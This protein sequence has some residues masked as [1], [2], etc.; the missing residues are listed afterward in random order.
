MP[1]AFSVSTTDGV[2]ILDWRVEGQALN[3]LDIN[4]IESLK[5]GV[6]GAADNDDVAGIVIT[7]PG[8]HFGGG[9]DISLL[10][11][12]SDGTL[13]INAAY[14]FARRLHAVFRRI[15]TCGKPV[16]AALPGTAAAGAFEL[17]LSCHRRF[18]AENPEARIGLPEIRIGL[19]PGIGGTTRLIRM[20]GLERAGPLLL[21]GRML[22]PEQALK[23]GMVDEV[24]PADSLRARAVRW[25][26]KANGE[27]ATQ[28]WDR[29]GH[30]IPGG[31]AYTRNGANVFAGASA[32]T[33]P[34]NRGNYPAIEALLAV[35]YEGT[36]VSFETALRIEARWIARVLGDPRAKS[37]IRT[38]FLSSRALARGVRRPRTARPAPLSRIG[39]VGAG[40][41]GAGIAYSAA[42][43][44]MHVMLLD[45]DQ[46]AAERGAETVMRI[47]EAGVKRG[48]QSETKAHAI[49]ERVDIGT[50]S[51]ELAECELVIEAV[52]EDPVL[53]GE[54]L[55]RAAS[56]VSKET[57]IATN[58]STLPIT[59]LAA[60][61]PSPER[62]VGIHFFSPVERMRLVEIIRGKATG[63]VAV[64]R[65]LDLVSALGKT[66]IVVRDARFFY[67]N[68]CIIPYTLEAASM[69]EE[70]VNPIRIERGALAAGMPIGCLQLVDE[71]SLSLGFQI[72]VAA[73]AENESSRNPLP[74][75]QVF[76]RLVTQERRLGRKAGAGFYDYANGE[77]VGLWPGLRELWPSSPDQPDP[78]VL[79]ERL[80]AIQAVEA[81][82]ALEEGVLEDIREGD[83]GAVL[84]WGFAPWSGGPFAWMDS[85]GA[86]G[87][88]G[89]LDRLAG[90]YGP[91]FEPPALLRGMAAKGDTF[92]R[93]SRER[94]GLI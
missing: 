36:L 64:G 54:V 5:A 76:R 42:A 22:R 13:G 50:E 56:V 77:R 19:F 81:V 55:S 29:R 83:V 32:L 91:R 14:E 68:R 26:K 34:R 20:L 39:I 84:G 1:G 48:R 67:A 57:V 31:N 51:D 23:H 52:F 18:A 49:G 11:S 59:R 78:K 65:A 33:N 46:Q 88:V 8:P 4:G 21:E 87:A 69:I 82:R 63:D 37:M 25:V 44:G 12:L 86:E 92:Y 93:R 38:N 66:P 70:G 41:M 6:E 16:A 45:R 58:T 43:A 85:M 9:V 27:A 73:R 2:V 53:K 30:R 72:L 94:D 89:L 7:S 90:R 74:G 61:V 17:A 79:G 62:F 35:A 24:V 60:A 47:A 3:L 40:M 15:E 75:E 28:P 71:T 10:E 80:L